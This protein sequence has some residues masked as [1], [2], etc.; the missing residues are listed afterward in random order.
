MVL[1]G[2]ENSIADVEKLDSFLLGNNSTNLLVKSESVSAYGLFRDAEDSLLI[3]DNLIL[4][5]GK[6]FGE[7]SFGSVIAAKNLNKNQEKHRH[8]ISRSHFANNFRSFSFDESLNDSLTIFTAEHHENTTEYRGD[9][10][11]LTDYLQREVPQGT[12]EALDVFNIPDEINDLDHLENEI[13]QVNELYEE[14]KGSFEYYKE[15]KKDYDLEELSGSNQEVFERLSGFDSLDDEDLNFTAIKDPADEGFLLRFLSSEITLNEGDWEE[16]R[17]YLLDEISEPEVRALKLFD[18]EEKIEETSQFIDHIQELGDKFEE[19]R[20]NYDGLSFAEKSLGF[21]VGDSNEEKYRSLRDVNIRKFS[22]PRDSDAL[23]NR[24]VGVEENGKV[25]IGYELDRRE[26]ESVS[27]EVEEDLE[28]IFSYFEESEADDFG[29][30][31]MFDI[32]DAVEDK[33]NIIEALR[34]L[35]NRYDEVSSNYDTYQSLDQLMDLPELEGSNEEIY[36]QIM[37]LEGLEEAIADYLGIEESAATRLTE[38]EEPEYWIKNLAT[39]SSDSI[40]EISMELGGHLIKGGFQEFVYGLVNHSY[41]KTK[42]ALRKVRRSEIDVEE[43]IYDFTGERNQD[44]LI[45]PDF[46][47]QKFLSP[48]ETVDNN[49]EAVLNESYEQGIYLLEKIRKN[50][51]NLKIEEPGG[52]VEE[53]LRAELEEYREQI[54]RGEVSYGEVQDEIQRLNDQIESAQQNKAEMYI[55]QWFDDLAADLGELEDSAFDRI[56]PDE[57]DISPDDLDHALNQAKQHLLKKRSKAYDQTKD[58]INGLKL[59]GPEISEGE[60]YMNVLDKSMEEG[61]PTYNETRCCA[62]PGGQIEELAMQY[63]QDPH[64]Q[65]IEIENGQEKGVAVAYRLEGLSD[66]TLFVETLETHGN[67]FRDRDLVEGVTEGLEEYADEAGFDNLMVNALSSN[68]APRQ[69]V[70]TLSE[71]DDYESNIRFGRKP[72]GN[73]YNE[74]L[75]LVSSLMSSFSPEDVPVYYGLERAD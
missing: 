74:S 46:S 25:K 73:F 2:A 34:D 68:S 48:D 6:K 24:L 17:E 31:H 64:T 51:L 28:D 71:M 18:F 72:G 54:S 14:V 67:I 43:F 44:V 8:R 47:A 75:T 52:G 1:R 53:E 39:V 66:E 7:R 62:F 61:L 9:W 55:R 59:S 60:I 5:D 63:M 35:E 58:I 56:D 11:R 42:K 49:P 22:L 4:P 3:T 50:E 30:L 20:E 38:V 57:V 13:D 70:E 40:P 19:V 21:E 65:I 10:E 69:F 27:L 26:Y 15:L 36:R 29:F 12:F 37:E 33:E 23:V 16:L 45:N 32:E 41:K